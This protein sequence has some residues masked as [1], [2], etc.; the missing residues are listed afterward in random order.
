MHFEGE[1]GDIARRNWRSPT[2][3]RSAI[4]DNERRSLLDGIVNLLILVGGIGKLPLLHA[5]VNGGLVCS[6]RIDSRCGEYTAVVVTTGLGTTAVDGAV[7][8]LE[9]RARAVG[10]K[11]NQLVALWQSRCSSQ[12]IFGYGTDGLAVT[13]ANVDEIGGSAATTATSTRNVSSCGTP[14]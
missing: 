14:K 10:C 1:N 4:L 5:L 6:S 7:T 12:E 13:R 2:G 8:V 9:Q 3:K 11:S